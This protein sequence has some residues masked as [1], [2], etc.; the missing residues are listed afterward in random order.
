MKLDMGRA[1][2]E[3]TA[4]IGAN[5][6][7][8]TIVA[9][10][11]FFL[12]YLAMALL[13]PQVLQGQTEMMGDPADAQAAVDALFA[14]YAKNW[15]AFLLVAVAQIIGTL[16]LLVLLSDTARP[17]VGE[18]LERGARGFLS[19]IGAQLLFAIGLG[20]LIG[21]PAAL[22]LASGSQAAFVLVIALA[23]VV[24]IYCA[25]KISL[26]GP[27]IAIDGLLNPVAILARSWRL[28]KGNSFRL[29]MFYLLL[30]VAIA[31]VAIVVTLVFGLVFAA[32]GS[33]IETI[34]NGVVA[35]LV[36]AVV[37]V[38]FLAVLAAVHRQLAGSAS[39]Q[40]GVTFE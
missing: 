35:S 1:W 24:G 5:R 6:Q 18:A 37:T 39:G 2:N 25:V 34:G 31:V 20:L 15:W 17:T 8:V 36:N 28:T 32:L 21:V 4:M 26:V 9:G 30:I 16:A 38:I 22:A 33:E 11:F 10:M 19:Y 7:M 13:M 12:P 29:A 40:A 3:G 23:I 14:L 27:A